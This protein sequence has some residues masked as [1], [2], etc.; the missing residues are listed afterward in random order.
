MGEP[1]PC[2]TPAVLTKPAFWH[3]VRVSTLS[4]CFPAVVVH[5]VSA[6]D[7]LLLNFN[8]LGT[9][10]SHVVLHLTFSFCFEVT[11]FTA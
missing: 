2:L 8:S 5:E 3:Y 6:C 9:L 7:I 1:A 4:D 10:L 11:V